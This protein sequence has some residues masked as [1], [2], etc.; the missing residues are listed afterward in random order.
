MEYSIRNIER[1]V[2]DSLSIFCTETA[3][4]V[5]FSGSL[6]RSIVP[7]R[8]KEST[9]LGMRDIL[10]QMNSA[11]CSTCWKILFIERF[12]L[13]KSF[14]LLESFSSS[15]NFSLLKTSV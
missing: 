3:D 8:S 5:T 11:P 7:P 9:Y 4:H 13:L 10:E 2:A 15:E 12:S 6:L 1:D 14:S